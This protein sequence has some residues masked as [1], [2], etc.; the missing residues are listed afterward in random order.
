M[1]PHRLLWISIALT[2]AALLAWLIS[3]YI[4]QSL[5]LPALEFAWLARNYLAIIP[6]DWLWSLVLV[7]VLGLT[8]W[9]LGVTR[10][11]SPTAWVK[12]PGGQAQ[13][14]ELAFWLGRVNNGPYQRWFVAHHLASLAIDMLRA[15]G[16][17]IERG[18]RLAGPGWNPP[19]DVQKYLEAA[20]YSSPITFGPAAKSAGLQTDPPIQAVIE[21]LE[22][23]MM[24]TSN[25]H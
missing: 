2:A 7:A 14:R 25:E 23:Y 12:H 5:I 9:A 19:Q 15:R 10:I 20:M 21:Y 22:T 4:Q 11:V 24:E 13:G 3:G 6:Q 18:S 17:Q 8:I 1:N 16:V